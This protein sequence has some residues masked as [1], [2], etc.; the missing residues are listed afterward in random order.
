MAVVPQDMTAEPFTAVALRAAPV[1]DRSRFQSRGAWAVVG[2]VV[3]WNLVN[4]RAETVAVPYLD[5]SSVHEQMVRFAT[6]QFQAGHLPL[7]SWF[8]YLGLGSPQFLHY[9]SLPAMLTGLVGILVGPDPAF[10]WSLYILLCAWP[11]SV[12]VGARL[13]GISRWGAA[14]AAAMSP[15]LMSVT[16]VGYEQKAYLWIGYGVWTQLWASVTLPLA[17]GFSWQAIHK[18]RHFFCAV[19]AVSLTVAL[20]FETGYLALLPLLLWP[21][22]SRRSILLRAG[23]A[24]VVIVGA[25]VACAWVIVPLVVERNYAATNEILQRTPLVNGYGGGRVLGWL[26]SGHLLDGGRLPVVTVLAGIGVALALARWRRDAVGRALLAVFAGCVLLSFGR[27]TFGSLIDLVPGHSDIF[28]RRFMMGAQLAALFLAGRGLAWCA[29]KAWD[30]SHRIVLGSSGR[31][32][33][34]GN[35]RLGGSIVVA[36]AGLVLLA[37]AWLQ[38]FSFDRDN[39][40]GIAAQRV[41]DQLQGRQVDRLIAIV[42]RNGGGRVYAGMPSNWGAA[43]RIGA[44]PVFKYLESRDVDE[45]GY[46]LRTASL[47]T[48]PEFYFD[49]RNPSDYRLF[50]IRY[51]IRPPALGSPVP[52]HLITCAGSYCLWEL[53]SN[54]YIQVG[55]VVGALAADRTNVGL[56]SR[57][58]LWSPLARR[59]AYLRLSLGT[60]E[61]SPSRIA[62]GVPPSGAGDVVGQESDLEH[63]SALASVRTPQAAVVVLS[64]SFDPAWTAEV[65]GRAASVFPV[66]PALVATSV[67]AGIHR[68]QFRYVGFSNYLV[69]FL[70]SAVALASVAIVDLTRPTGRY[71]RSRSQP[72]LRAGS[73]ERL[74][75]LSVAV[76]SGIGA[77]LN[78]GLDEDGP[79]GRFDAGISQRMGEV[80]CRE[81]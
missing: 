65:D 45:V 13:F 47:M 20:H 5:D 50:G 17:W 16:G 40:G 53:P 3:A 62:E 14:A 67:P 48:D 74:A 54:G 81:N 6:L 70:L 36:A 69:L 72:Q 63:G 79:A 34:S 35:A 46:T 33:S 66:A 59:Q 19:V 18:G 55:R 32:G 41:A 73:E 68:V 57:A 9:Q 51:L 25:V 27:T 22:V 29:G 77:V 78:G 60:P 43:F 28:F 7:T 30:A 49:E 15:L 75:R 4:L 10:R 71:G 31:L 42:K 11:I 58:L 12:Y 80:T 38:V 52:A 23:R 56:R 37:P 2:A 64:A 24:A 39:A 76:G 21:F 61:R 8:P 1:A 44:V 26:V